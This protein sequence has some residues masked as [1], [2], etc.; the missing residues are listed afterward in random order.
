MC[1]CVCVCVCVLFLSYSSPQVSRC[2]A[3]VPELCGGGGWWCWW[4]CSCFILA[5]GSRSVAQVPE[6][7]VGDMVRI[8]SD[9]ELVKMLNKHIGW[10]S[11]MEEVMKTDTV[12]LDHTLIIII[13]IIIICPLTARVIGTQQMTWQPVSSIFSCSPMPSG[14]W[15]TP[16]LSI[17]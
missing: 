6:L 10:K 1:V 17:P 15:G 12:P 2:I 9:P 13:I 4:Y 7:S 8:H 5:Q 14:T 3:Q 16:G 11:D